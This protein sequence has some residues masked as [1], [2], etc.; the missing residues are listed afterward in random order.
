MKKAIIILIAIDD[1]GLSVLS[2][3]VVAV[4]SVMVI[5]CI[6]VIIILSV[7]LIKTRQRKEH[8]YD[9]GNALSK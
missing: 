5:A 8:S 7:V 1:G 9:Y 6:V 3:A 4:L 2:A